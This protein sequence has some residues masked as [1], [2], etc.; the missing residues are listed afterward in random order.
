MAMR[1]DGAVV[2]LFLSCG[3]SCAGVE[4]E[5]DDVSVVHDVVP[6][7]LTVFSGGLKEKHNRKKFR[8][9]S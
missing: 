7:L 9:Y 1:W 2:L 3:E 6:T 5:E 4:L 8:S